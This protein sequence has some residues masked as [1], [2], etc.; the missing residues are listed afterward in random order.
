[1]SNPPPLPFEES[2]EQPEMA[3]DSV[4]VWRRVC[5]LLLFAAYPVVLGLLGASRAS[6]HR[7]PLLPSNIPKL[8]LVCAIEIAFF[9][10]F[11]GTGWVL[12]RV[13]GKDLYLKWRRGL[14]PILQGAG[15]S[16]LLRMLIVVVVVVGGVFLTATHIVKP[17]D[18]GH[19]VSQNRP[20]LD[21]LVSSNAIQKSA[22]YFWLNVTLISFIVAGLREELWRAGLLAGFRRLWPQVFG[23]EAGQMIAVCIG[24][25]LFGLGH[26]P[27]GWLGVVATT[28]LGLALGTIMVKHRSIWPAVIAHGAFDATTFAMLRV[29]PGILHSHAGLFH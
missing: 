11:F 22:A 12:A 24:A 3:G 5:Y 4:P 16:V 26:L 7:S 19:F 6:A 27:Q 20:N 13:T 10:I 25:V 17:D 14:W 1:M 29:L 28:V 21:Y 15:Y 8:L 18:L 2:S 9:A 23:S